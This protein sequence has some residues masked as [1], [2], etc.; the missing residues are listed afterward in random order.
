M[1]IIIVMKYA[2]V[3][4]I[5]IMYMAVIAN[6]MKRRMPADEKLVKKCFVSSKTESV[7]KKI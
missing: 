3:R 4:K 6:Y 2:A 5:Y 7:N 1:K